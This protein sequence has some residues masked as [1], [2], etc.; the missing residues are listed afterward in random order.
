VQGSHPPHL[1]IGSIES[2]SMSYAL[3]AFEESGDLKRLLGLRDQLERVRQNIDE[4]KDYRPAKPVFRRSYGYEFF[5]EV[6]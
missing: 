3:E 2:S 6:I 1:N 5:L 4:I